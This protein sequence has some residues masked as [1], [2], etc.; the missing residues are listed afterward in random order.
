MRC[1]FAAP[2]GMHY[3]KVL[4]FSLDSYSCYDVMQQPQATQLSELLRTTQ[5][6]RLQMQH[7]GFR[8]FRCSRF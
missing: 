5:K 4:N 1:V 6:Q 3:T 8:C 7:N 2:I